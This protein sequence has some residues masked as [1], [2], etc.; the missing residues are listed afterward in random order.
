MQE[1]EIIPPVLSA[2][3]VLG[4]SSSFSS[5]EVKLAP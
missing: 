4:T 3:I 1:E 2:I 5:Y